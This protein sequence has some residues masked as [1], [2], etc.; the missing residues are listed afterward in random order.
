MPTSSRN[1]TNHSGPISRS[2]SCRPW[3]VARRSRGWLRIRWVMGRR[4]RSTNSA[5]RSAAVT[6]ASRPA[7]CETP[8]PNTLMI[9]GSCSESPSAAAADQPQRRQRAPVQD[10]QRPGAVRAVQQRQTDQRQRRE[11]R[12]GQQH[13]GQHQRAELSHGIGHGDGQVQRDHERDGP[14]RQLHRRHPQQLPGLRPAGRSTGCLAAACRR[15]VI[16][17]RPSARPAQIAVTIR[18]SRI[19]DGHS[20]RR[21]GRL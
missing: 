2:S 18:K 3:R 14:G 8:G 21:G 17:R 11:Q 20:R 13:I 4:K 12:A 16:Q 15:R 6:L 10:V 7:N 5:L 9:S 19:S 1:G